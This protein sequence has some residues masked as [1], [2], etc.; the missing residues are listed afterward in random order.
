MAERLFLDQQG[1][2]IRAAMAAALHSHLFPRRRAL[3]ARPPDRKRALAIKLF[4]L[5]R[6]EGSA[7][8]A[9]RVRVYSLSIGFTPHPS[10]LPM[11][12][13]V[14]CGAITSISKVPSFGVGRPPPPVGLS[15][16]GSAAIR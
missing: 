11:G 3:F 7:C 10:H 2:R 9:H 6:G 13:G 5:S 1:L 16:S 12:E 8:E 14:Y 15:G 4:H